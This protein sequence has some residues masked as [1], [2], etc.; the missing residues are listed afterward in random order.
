MFF[1]LIFKYY[2]SF[3]FTRFTAWDKKNAGI[4]AKKENVNVKIIRER[5]SKKREKWWEEKLLLSLVSQCNTITFITS[6]FSPTFPSLSSYFTSLLPIYHFTLASFACPISLP[7][8]F[9][10]FL[11]FSFLQ[12]ERE[13]ERKSIIFSSTNT[14]PVTVSKQSRWI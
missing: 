9:L 1:F 4:G 11:P 2:F 5:E 12:P 13:K 8:S 14:Y 3:F 7:H 6:F 10:P